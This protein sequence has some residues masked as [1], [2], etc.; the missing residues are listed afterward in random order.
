MVDRVRTALSYTFVDHP[1]DLEARQGEVVRRDRNEYLVPVQ[2]RIPLDNV[3]LLPRADGKH[4]ARLRLFVAA[5]DE[6]GRASDIEEVP[7]GFRPPAEAAPDAGG[8]PEGRDRR[9][10]RVRRDALGRVG[11]GEGGGRRA[12]AGGPAEVRLPRRRPDRSY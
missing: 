8:A 11:A 9:A 5:I 3:V 2:V 7:I 12:A 1:L 10:R 6:Q 4:E